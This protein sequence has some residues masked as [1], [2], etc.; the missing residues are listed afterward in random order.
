MQLALLPWLLLA[1]AGGT[2]PGAAAHTPDMALNTHLLYG[3]YSVAAQATTTTTTTISA[4]ATTAVSA[5]AT[6][7][8]ST[9]PPLP[10]AT[11]GGSLQLNPFDLA[12][13]TSEPNPPL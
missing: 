3:Q 6:I 4:T 5:T 12:F 9:L 11:S 8:Q 13:L 7:T 2:M 1:M 10:S